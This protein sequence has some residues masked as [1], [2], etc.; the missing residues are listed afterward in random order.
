MT[1]VLEK[2]EN[3]FGAWLDNCPDEFSGITTIG[4]TE[5]EVTD[6]VRMLIRDFLKNDFPDYP[7]F[8]GLKPDEIVFNYRYSLVDFFDSFSALKINSI[9]DLAG[10]NRSLVRQYASGAATA[11][12]AQAKKIQE[13]I[14]AFARSLLQVSVV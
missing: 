13:A 2:T 7:K 9:A 5:G 12:A 4:A 6:N 10:L 3:G 14:L 11:S 1:I 8:I